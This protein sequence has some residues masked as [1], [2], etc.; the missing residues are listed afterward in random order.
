MDACACAAL[1]SFFFF[2]RPLKAAALAPGPDGVPAHSSPRIR[3]VH[4]GMH[5][6]EKEN[7]TA[8]LTVTVSSNPAAVAR[9]TLFFLPLLRPSALDFLSDEILAE[10]KE[11]RREK[12]RR[13]PAEDEEK[14]G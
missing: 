12:R 6:R 2:A 11:G 5:T 10:L 13:R 1:F 3:A 8:P 14:E 4:T 9:S 7:T